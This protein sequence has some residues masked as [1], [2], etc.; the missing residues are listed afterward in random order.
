MFL[1]V[2]MTVYNGEKYLQ[3]CIQSVLNQ[4]YKNFEFIIV[5]DGSNDN[6]KVILDNINDS[7][8]RIFHLETNHGQTFCLNFGIKHAKGDWVVRQDADDISLINRFEEQVK[9]IQEN[10]HI[11]GVGTQIKSIPADATV[12]D[13]RLR[14]VEW[15]NSL[16]T[17]EEIEEYR[18][19]APPVIHGTMMFS[20][21][22]FM[23]IGGYSEEYK[24]AQDFDLWIRL[25]QSG[26]IEKVPKILYQYRL[27]LGSLSNKDEIKTCYES[28]LVASSH[29]RKLVYEKEN[30]SF[31]VIGP[32]KG[33]K[34]FI[35]QIC[36][37]RHLNIKKNYPYDEVGDF[38]KLYRSVLKRRINAVIVL[39]G[40]KSFSILEQLK[41]MGMEMNKNLF[42]LWNIHE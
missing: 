10:P 35:K 39:D 2:V 16:I 22:V 32:S 24:I 4:T 40:T 41:K 14:A 31:A 23:D 27:D 7:R 15:S 42:R 3:D 17:R 18:F 34:Y 20:K 28:L 6:T 11:V 13:Q 1:S 5:N 21:Q 9:Y 33:C 19:I 36:P 30:P 12:N 37:L 25:M 29:I 26:P 38:S 8:V